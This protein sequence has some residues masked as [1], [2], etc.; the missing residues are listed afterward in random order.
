MGGRRACRHAQGGAEVAGRLL[1]LTPL[2][3][4]APTFRSQP[5][6]PPARNYISRKDVGAR[7]RTGASA[8]A[9]VLSRA[10]KLPG[11]ESKGRDH[12]AP[13]GPGETGR[14]GSG[15]EAGGSLAP[16]RAELQA[17]GAAPVGWCSWR[18]AGRGSRARG[19]PADSQGGTAGGARGRWP[20]RATLL[21]WRMSAR[22]A[23]SRVGLVKGASFPGRRERRTAEP[24]AA[25]FW[26]C[27]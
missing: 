1:P 5:R 12:P 4:A 20:G 27:A 18:Q 21:R 6:A 25:A 7:T 15:G 22:A 10:L 14:R 2:H 23:V 26:G 19:E 9:T 3:R 17:S 24:P 11:K 13:A 8:M 16:T